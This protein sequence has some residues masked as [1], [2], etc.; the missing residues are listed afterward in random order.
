M[1]WLL[2]SACCATRAPWRAGIQV[3]TLASASSPARRNVAVVGTGRMGQIRLAGMALDPRIQIAAIV[4][5]ATT[6]AEKSRMENDY[7][8][9]CFP[10]VEE[11]SASLAAQGLELDGIWIA[12]PTPSHL[13]IIQECVK[14]KRTTARGLRAIGIEKPVGGTIE[15]I[16]EAYS[17]SAAAEIQLCCSFQRRFDPSY[18]ALL[19]ACLD[20]KRIGRIQSIH[21]VFRDHPCPPIEFLKN[22]GDPFHDLAVH[23][24]DYVCHLLNEFPTRVYAYGTS[25]SQELRE[26]NV[27][28]KASVWLEFERSGVICTMDLSRSAVYGYDQRIEVAGE[29]G[30]LQVQNPSKTTLL[31]SSEKGIEAQP[32]VHS[33]PQ[34][35][36]EAYLHEMDHFVNVLNGNESPQVS[37]NAARMATVVS[38]AARIAAVH[39]KVVTI[40]YTGSRQINDNCHDILAVCELDY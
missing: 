34:R 27:M 15:E 28:D 30:M 4:D 2:S 20:Q 22:G 40:R 38:E 5:S 21:T 8:T 39:R 13:G 36:Q 19:T 3:R 29:S 18:K 1:R 6:N 17:A 11:A 10:S 25:L 32:L 23:D 9:A 33:F 7:R 14:F 26:V 31:C 35:F 12:T 24:I 16:D 37:W